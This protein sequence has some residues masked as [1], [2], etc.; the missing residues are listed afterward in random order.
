MV[1]VRR[2]L[3]LVD[4]DHLLDALDVLEV[5]ALAVA[6]APRPELGGRCDFEHDPREVAAA[7]GNVGDPG[8]A[9]LL[10]P[11]CG[12]GADLRPT[13]ILVATQPGHEGGG[14]ARDDGAVLRRRGGL[15]DDPAVDQ[16][17]APGRAELGLVPGLVPGQEARRGSGL[18]R[19][20]GGIHVRLRPNGSRS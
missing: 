10:L 20:F 17:V 2:H 16:L 11:G 6:G 7:D 9:A 8:G 3:V 4:L 1:G 18:S 12:T 14:Q 15:P 5:A 13:P 19:L